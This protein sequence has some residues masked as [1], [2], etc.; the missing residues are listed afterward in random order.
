MNEFVAKMQLYLLEL[1]ELGEQFINEIID[2]EN[3]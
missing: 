3:K 1:D 2:S